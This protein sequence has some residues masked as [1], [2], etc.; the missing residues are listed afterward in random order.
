MTSSATQKIHA[1][2]ATPRW[3]LA[4][5]LAGLAMLGPFAIDTYIPAF[6]GMGRELGANV[7][8]MQQTFSV[9]LAAFAFM[10]LFHGALSDSY[11]RKPIIVVGLVGFLIGSV[12]CALSNSIGALLL[13]RAVQGLSVGAGMVVGRAMIR[14]LFNETDAQ[15]LM[16]MVTL[17]FGIAPAIAPIIG[18]HLYVRLGWHS[19]FWM[20]A[21]MATVLIAVVSFSI[22]ETLPANKRQPFRPGPLFAG[23]R[24]VGANVPF[25]LLSLAVGFNFN[26]F[27]LY[28][29]SAPVYLT[30]S[31]KLGPQEFAWLFIPGI[32]G[33]ML[34]AFISGRVAGKLKFAATVS[35]A[36]RFMVIAALINLLY[37][38]VF[39][40]S[41]PWA[42]IPLF[43]YAIGSAMAMPSLS[44]IVLD[45][46]PTRRGMAASLQGFVS[47]I[48]NALVAGLVSPAVSHSPLLLALAM[49]GLMGAGLL[50]W[51]M[52]RRMGRG[53]AARAAQ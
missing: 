48:I 38:A 5:L 37:A 35:Y 12:G 28:F 9:Y 31:L 50:C 22:H 19:I 34:G 40:P 3:L 17:W 29:M 21:M 45:L 32:G 4:L 33:I 24:E 43:F 25:L 15:K 13:F 36:Y 23:Y 7:V 47:G 14:D 6:D 39:A 49:V 10:F 2:H 18:G 11:G 44:L 26:A 53:V 46:F 1:H 51:T 8:Q 20:L 27:F 30:H 16:S 42:I 52:F 41:V